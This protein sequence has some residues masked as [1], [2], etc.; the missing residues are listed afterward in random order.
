MNELIQKNSMLA[1]I[2]LAVVGV[3]DDPV[4]IVGHPGVDFTNQSRQ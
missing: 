4:P 1:W 2:A 3:L